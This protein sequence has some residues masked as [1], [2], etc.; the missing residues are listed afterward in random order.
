MHPVGLAHCTQH[1]RGVDISMRKV[2]MCAH[3]AL[4]DIVT[5]LLSGTTD[6]TVCFEQALA[7]LS[8]N[9]TRAHPRRDRRIG[10]LELGTEHVGVGA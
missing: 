6:L 3:H 9:A 8:T 5:R 2:A 7:Y 10:R 1:L 4:R